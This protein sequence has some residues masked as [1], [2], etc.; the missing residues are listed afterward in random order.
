MRIT[1]KTLLLATV[2][3]IAV[4]LAVSAQSLYGSGS[5]NAGVSAQTGSLQVPVT[6]VSV[7]ASGSAQGQGDSGYQ[8][9]TGAVLN[10]ASESASGSTDANGM[11]MVTASDAASGGTTLTSS[12]QVMTDDDFAAFARGTIKSNTALE[13]VAAS[14]NSVTVE[15]REPGRVIG[16]FPV[17]MNSSATIASNGMVSISHP[18]YYFLTSTASDASLRTALSTEAAGAFNQ[19]PS[20]ASEGATSTASGESVLSASEKA[21]L[22][23]G[24]NLAL[25]STLAASST[26][27]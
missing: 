21:R 6:S 17:I 1:S 5:M 8:S 16:L 12:S 22:L 25:G 3:L 19:T 9:G 15:Y 2:A 4:P 14:D 11:F 7:D 18:W 13:A 10:T 27:Y 26:S 20:R 23:A 24:I